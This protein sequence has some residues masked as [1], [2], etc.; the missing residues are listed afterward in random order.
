MSDLDRFYR[1]VME[2]QDEIEHY[3]NKNSGRYRRGSG[4]HPDST[5]SGR[6]TREKLERDERF[7][8]GIPRDAS[9]N[10]PRPLKPNGKMPI[11]SKGASE[12]E[13]AQAEKALGV[14]FSQEF[15]TLIQKNGSIST[16]GHEIL[17]VDPAHPRL[18]TVKVT[19][20]ERIRNPKTALKD[21]YIIEDPGIDDIKVWQKADGTVHQT[22]PT[23]M[24]P[25]MKIADSLSSWVNT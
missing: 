6:T 1:A 3:G 12:A 2:A 23:N 25:N 16:N 20:E 24:W 19:K 21:A 9:I 22:C 8:R 15:K 17:G 4:K 7:T 13:V 14:N 10:S 11:G 18:D 5:G